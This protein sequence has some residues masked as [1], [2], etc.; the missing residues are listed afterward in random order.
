MP[1]ERSPESVEPKK[2]RIHARHRVVVGDCDLLRLLDALSLRLGCLC[3]DGNAVKSCQAHEK[4]SMRLC[5][6]FSARATPAASAREN[7]FD[8]VARVHSSAYPNF[9]DSVG[10]KSLM[11]TLKKMRRKYGS[12]GKTVLQYTLSADLVAE[13]YPKVS[14]ANKVS[15]ESDCCSAFGGF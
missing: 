4:R 10:G 3:T 13:E 6:R 5:S 8:C 1:R 7:V 12:L 11:Y 9:S 14:L 2:T 15:D